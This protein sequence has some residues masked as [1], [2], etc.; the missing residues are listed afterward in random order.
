MWDN[1]IFTGGEVIRWQYNKGTWG[2]EIIF[3]CLQLSK[4]ILKGNLDFI[5]NKMLLKA[6]CPP[7][8]K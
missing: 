8:L 7:D 3:K 1:S 6:I 2:F 4:L 5:P